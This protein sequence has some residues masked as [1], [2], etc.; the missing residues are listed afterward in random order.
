[1]K[2]TPTQDLIME[3][4]AARARLGEPF[5]TFSTVLSPMARA[6]CDLGLV[7]IDSAVTGD[8]RLRLTQEGREEYLSTSYSPPG[9]ELSKAWHEG[10]KSMSDDIRTGSST[11]NPYA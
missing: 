2:L 10:R 1:M 8:M 9:G 6:L 5:W 3:V 4:L 11:S 7:T